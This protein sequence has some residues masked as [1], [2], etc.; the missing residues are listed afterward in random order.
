M[1][2]EAG[3]ERVLTLNLSNYFAKMQKVHRVPQE[4]LVCS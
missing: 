2:Q 3:G 1:E 4:H